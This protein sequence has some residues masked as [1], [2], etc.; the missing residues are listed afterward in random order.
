M[1]YNS[2]MTCNIDAK[3]RAMRRAGGILC[4]VLG[5]LLLGLAFAV[6]GFRWLLIGLGLILVAAGVFQ[7]Y[8]SRKGWCALRAM[9]VKT[10]F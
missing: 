4:C 2:C 8:E 3:G 9:G 10:P 6:H 7:F 5:V 1:T